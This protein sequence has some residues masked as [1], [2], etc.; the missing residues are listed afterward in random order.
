MSAND[1][2]LQRKERKYIILEHT[3]D[4][5]IEEIQTHIPIYQHNGNPGIVNIETTYLD[6][7]DF[8]LYNEFLNNRK[9]RYK[10][11]MRRYGYDG[12]FAPEYLVELKIKYNSISSKK[13]FVLPAAHYDTFVRNGDLRAE[14]KEANNGMMGAQKTYRLIHKLISINGFVPV[15]RTTYTR[16]AFQKV[17]KRVRV[18][19][20][21]GI[22][23]QALLGKPR[24]ATLD[25]VVLESKIMGKTPKWHKNMVSLLSLLRQQ[26]FSKYATGINSIYFPERGKYYFFGEKEQAIPEMPQKITAS[27]ELLKTALKLVEEPTGV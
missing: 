9:F 15:L 1:L 10:I 5:I 11:R 4:E 16:I 24:T 18:T 19:V 22:S 20:D 14:V 6:T 12:V 3:F 13:R 27:F 23:H 21:K 17:S 26:R 25:A 2:S 8:L 7:E